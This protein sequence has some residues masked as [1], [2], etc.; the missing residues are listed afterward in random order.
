MHDGRYPRSQPIP[1]DAPLEPRLARVRP[2]AHEPRLALVMWLVAGLVV[3]AAV[4]PW[5]AAAPVA[6]L[7][8]D[9][10]APTL[11]VTPLP[12]LDRTPEGL[13]MPACLGT[14]AW[15]IATLERW[16]D[17]D[18]RVWRAIVP[19]ASASGP[20]DPAIPTVPV[21]ADL[22]T[23]LGWCAPAFGPEEPI[24]PANVNAW[25]VTARGADPLTLRQVQP[26]DG[27][28]PI[29]A[30]YL[31][32]DGPWAS[33]LV[34]F[35]YEDTGTGRVGWFG[36]ELTVRGGASPAPTRRPVHGPGWTQQ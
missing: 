14:G 36:A 7:R 17:G 13:A 34:V 27:V 5:G 23:G 24:G 1:E 28:T 16:R 35:R 20:L 10:A 11:E 9:P 22:V 21:F 2:P 4:K 29:A 25:L 15:R 31:P 8:P 12:T 30:L 6:P 19:L 18:V 33:G 26:A 3:V 32:A